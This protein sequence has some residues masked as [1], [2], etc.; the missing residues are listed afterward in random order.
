MKD[1]MPALGQAIRI[2]G[3]SFQ[4]VGVVSPRMQ[5]AENDIN[6]T[7]YIPYNAMD[8]LQDNF[9]L[10]GIWLDY[11]GLDHEKVNKTIRDSLAV[12]HNFKPDDMRAVFVF[13][14]QKQLAQFNIITMDFVADHQQGL[15]WNHHLV[16]LHIIAYQHEDLLLGH[17]SSL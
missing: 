8:V 7:I 17:A 9:Y 15:K 11:E 4:I 14:A 2:N 1:G 3:V 13:D 16:I 12:A 6:R 10:G 5:E